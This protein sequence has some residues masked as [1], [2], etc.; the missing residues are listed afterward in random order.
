MSN[1]FL[2]H[3]V[4]HGDLGAILPVVTPKGTPL[5]IDF[6]KVDIHCG[7]FE[8]PYAEVMA[9]LPPSLHP[10]TPAYGSLTFYRVYD[11]PVGPFEF[12]VMGIAC[13][14]TI[15]PRMLTLSAFASTE[16]SAEFLCNNYGYS[17]EVADVRA[18]QPYH[19][20]ISE[21]T[22]NGH[23]IARMR[24]EDA[25]FL[26]GMARA[27]RYPQALNLSRVDGKM[28]LLQVDMVYEYDQSYR[29]HLI[30]ETFDS[31]AMTGGRIHPTDLI[32]STVVS[33]G[34]QIKPR[35]IVLD[36]D[37]VGGVTK[38]AAHEPVTA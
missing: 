15:K 17:C 5:L 1:P 11:S 35:K 32:A 10:S 9:I 19:G 8:M 31:Q 16:A 6:G 25:E 12:A 34:L 38:L 22:L 27:V 14:N 28:G 24:T 29:G 2:N 4:G 18:R 37:E 33:A 23:C 26:L 30:L 36:L 7:L 21:V 13:R 20:A 3:P